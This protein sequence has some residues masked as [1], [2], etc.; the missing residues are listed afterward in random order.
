[1]SGLQN[2]TDLVLDAAVYENG[3]Y[4]TASPSRLSKLIGQLDLFRASLPLP[5]E[6]VEC[7]VFKGASFLRW[8]KFRAA[9]STP[10][11]RR[12]IGFDTFGRF[13]EASNDGDRLLRERFVLSAGD[14]SISID[15]LTEILNEQLLN[16]NI[17]LIAGDVAET[18]PAY[19][20]AHPELKISLLNIDVD[21]AEPTLCC[22]D[23]LFD[24]VV[25]GGVILL[26]DYGAFPGANQAIDGF[27]A[28]R[29]EKPIRPAH[30]G[31]FTYVRKGRCELP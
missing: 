10:W 13:P 14:Q 19:L 28:G 9:L 6:I 21:L 1:M 16:Q 22:L 31:S 15:M 24:R 8:V 11:S 7:G 5:G 27:F 26:D 3:F 25:T 17:E 12:I 23:L 29:L 18:I 20:D 2:R 4:L 30:S